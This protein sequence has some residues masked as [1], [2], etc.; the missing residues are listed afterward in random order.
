MNLRAAFRGLDLAYALV[1]GVLLLVCALVTL[2]DVTGRNLFNAPLRG[3]TEM[4]EILLVA[5]VF[6]LFPR[7]AWRDSHLSV[8]LLD[9]LFGRWIRRLLA[10]VGALLGGALF[11]AMAWRLWAL[12]DRVSGFGDV[13]PSLRL[14]LGPVYY[15]MTALAAL[16]AAIY[17]LRT[18][19]VLFAYDRIPHDGRLPSET[20]A[21]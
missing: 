3:A 16:T 21:T 9:S 4:T 12:G 14:P 20:G 6:V 2:V 18:L 10:L 5:I 11:S 19:A 8:D 1:P 15:A 17:L 7:I 13:T